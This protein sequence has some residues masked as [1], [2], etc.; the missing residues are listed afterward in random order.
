MQW[1]WPPVTWAAFLLW[2]TPSLLSRR[3]SGSGDL[4]IT[5][6][7]VDCLGIDPAGTPRWRGPRGSARV[8]PKTRTAAGIVSGLPTIHELTWFVIT[9]ALSGSDLEC[10]RNCL[11]SARTRREIRGRWELSGPRK[12]KTRQQGKLVVL[13]RI[14]V[15]AYAAKKTLETGIRTQAVQH[16]ARF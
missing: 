11:W 6:I 14:L 16:Q 15:Q 9:R 2:Q 3:A 12:T 8:R 7:W 4:N 13:A 10:S 5:P 1:S